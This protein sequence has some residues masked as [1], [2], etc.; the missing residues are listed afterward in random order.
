LTGQYDICFRTNSF[1]SLY[2]VTGSAVN[3]VTA[4]NYQSMLLIQ[5][6]PYSTNKFRIETQNYA[7]NPFTSYSY[8]VLVQPQ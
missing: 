6:D 7:G 8:Q 2:Y 3:P 5:G 1:N 4:A